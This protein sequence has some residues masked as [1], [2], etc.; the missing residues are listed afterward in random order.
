MFNKYIYTTMCPICD[1]DTAVSIN[2][3]AEQ[4]NKNKP[5]AEIN[6]YIHTNKYLQHS[7]RNLMSLPFI[8]DSRKWVASITN[9]IIVLNMLTSIYKI[10]TTYSDFLSSTNGRR[11]T[12]L[13]NT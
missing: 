4:H 8:T 13:Q 12:S 1:Y 2:K 10:H 6:K 11:S 7:H 5:I 3:S 9:D